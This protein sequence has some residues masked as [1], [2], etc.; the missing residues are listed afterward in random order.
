MGAALSLTGMQWPGLKV[1]EGRCLNKVFTGLAARL[2]RCFF[3]SAA[4]YCVTPTVVNRQPKVVFLCRVFVVFS[5]TEN[6]PFILFFSPKHDRSRYFRC[7][8]EKPFGVGFG[9]LL[10]CKPKPTDLFG[11]KPKT[12]LGPFPFSVHNIGRA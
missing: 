11:E 12:D 6:R 5:K 7:F 3:L 1:A 8:T 10:C 4:Q 2:R 9:L